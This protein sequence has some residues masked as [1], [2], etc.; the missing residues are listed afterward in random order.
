[1]A[2]AKQRE[3][4]YKNKKAREKRERQRVQAELNLKNSHLHAKTLPA[5]KDSSGDLIPQSWY[6]IRTSQPERIKF[7]KSRYKEFRDIIMKQKAA[8]KDP[9]LQWV[10][11]PT[12]LLND[13][14]SYESTPSDELIT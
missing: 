14:Y 1:M 6:H 5:Q 13:L 4:D 9:K 8:R 7:L 12:S 2:D 10:E 3:R 11:M